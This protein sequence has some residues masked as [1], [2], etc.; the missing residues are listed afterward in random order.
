MS[1]ILAGKRRPGLDVAQRIAQAAGMTLQE[2][3][4]L[5]ETKPATTAKRS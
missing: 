5:I 1:Y 4:D 2:L 3:V